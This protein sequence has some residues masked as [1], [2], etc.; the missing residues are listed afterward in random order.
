MIQNLIGTQGLVGSKVGLVLEGPNVDA[1]CLYG[2]F[3]S[4]SLPYRDLG[5]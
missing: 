5:G 4:V 1:E 3:L 2:V